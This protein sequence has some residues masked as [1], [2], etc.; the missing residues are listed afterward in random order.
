MASV[1]ILFPVPQP[2]PASV[3][4]E[5]DRFHHLV[6]VLR[7][8]VGASLEVFDGEGRSYPARV[9]SLDATSAELALEAPTA[10]ARTLEVTLIQGLPK[11]DKLEWILQKGTELGATAFS[12]VQTARS[13]VRLEPA[14][15]AQKVLRWQKIV[16]EAARQCGRSDVP[17]VHAPRELLAAVE[18]LATGTR[19]LLL[20]EQ[21]RTVS[22]SDA[23]TDSRGLARFALLVGPEGGWD[24]EEV[25][26]LERL[27]AVPVSLGRNI[28]RTETAAIAGLAVLL[29]ALGALG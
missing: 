21:P 3:R 23:L 14:R 10:S 19:L 11:A 9:T 16:E 29:H 4:L 12:P 8:T 15:A 25:A 17:V 1:R 27:N 26:A 22:L 5:G 2:A 13:V 6:H 7:L 24:R 20:D 18:G 28:L